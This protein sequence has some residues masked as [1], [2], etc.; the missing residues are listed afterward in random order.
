M[1]GLT[2]TGGSNEGLNGVVS[3]SE[4]NAIITGGFNG[5]CP[6]YFIAYLNG[7]EN[8]VT[9][10]SFGINYGTG[11]L[12]KI[13]PQGEVLWTNTCHNRDVGLRPVGTDAENSQQKKKHQHDLKLEHRRLSLEAGDGGEGMPRG[14][15]PKFF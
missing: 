13:S 10:E 8:E 15:S 12:T 9:V 11:V 7:E 1:W 3:D 14:P 2:L 6:S 5:C 4:G